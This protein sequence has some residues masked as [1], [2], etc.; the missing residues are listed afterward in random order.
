MAKIKQSSKSS[1]ARKSSSGSTAIKS[2]SVSSQPSRQAQIASISKQANLIAG[3]MNTLASAEKAGLKVGGKTTVQEAEQFLKGGKNGLPQLGQEEIPTEPIT[4][5][6]TVVPTEAPVVPPAPVVAPGGTSS[7]PVGGAGGRARTTATTGGAVPSPIQAGFA[8]ATASG[9]S[10]PQTA[11]EARVAIQS[12]L[13]PESPVNP[14]DSIL[15]QDEGIQSII[16]SFQDFM[17]PKNQKESLVSTYREMIADSGIEDIDEDLID[18]RNIIEGTEDDIR[19]EVTKAG[20]F[21]TDSQVL[22]MTNA[23]NKSLIK[24][25]NTLLETRNAKSEYVNTLIGLEQQDREY[26][27]QQFDRMMNFTFR[28]ADYQNQMRQNASNQYNRI[29]ET[30]GYDGLLNSANDDPYTVSLI[31]NSLGLT[32]GGLTQLSA[33]SARV[34]AQA[35]E[36]RQLGLQLT[37]EQIKTQQAQRAGGGQ[38]DTQVVDM[39]GDRKVLIDSQTGETIRELSSA[40]TSFTE[41]AAAEAQSFIEEVGNLKTHRG[42]AKAVGPTGIA[43]F[44]PFKID[45]TTGDVADFVGTIDQIIPTLTIDKLLDAKAQG[46]TFGALN[47]QEWGALQASG[48]KLSSWRKEDEK[49]NVFFQASEKSVKKELDKIQNFA[50]LDYIIKGGSPQ[51]VGVQLMQDGSYWTVNS[52]GSYTKLI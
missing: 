50:K 32:S 43:R 42:M 45:V 33:E 8:H 46:A 6:E 35:E 2:T 48:S 9:V 39:G 13:P 52:D 44:T 47:E 37:R 7:V 24:N 21:A 25:Y 49:G 11:G 10:A 5:E 12:Y 18:M 34:K 14:V 51:D 20:G 19:T 26:A 1:I 16:Q 3:K 31:E 27:N 30:I 29:A 15:Q 28:I 23:R 17:S 38:R 22:A 36:E 4:P 41:Q 40:E